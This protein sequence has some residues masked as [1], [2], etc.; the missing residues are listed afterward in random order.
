MN[1]S[2]E[3]SNRRNKAIRDA[4]GKQVLYAMTAE[5]VKKL[6]EL[7]AKVDGIGSNN[8]ALD[9]CLNFAHQIMVTGG[10]P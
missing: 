4:G 6:D 7:K 5:Q 3:R 9:Y 1:K 10:T 2:T 8:D